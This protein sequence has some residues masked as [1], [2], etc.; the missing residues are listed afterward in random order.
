M[1]QIISFE[2]IDGAGKTYWAQ[3]I[4]DF[5]GEQAIYITRKNMAASNNAYINEMG[6]HF[7]KILWK[8]GYELPV[9]LIPD[10]AWLCLH[11]AW[12]F[13]FQENVL[14]QLLRKYKYVIL[15]GWFYKILARFWIKSEYT[16]QVLLERF[17]D[18][19]NADRI[20]FLDINPQKCFERKESFSKCELGLLDGE[21]RNNAASF[22]S[23]QNKVRKSYYEVFASLDLKIKVFDEF[24]DLKRLIKEFE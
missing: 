3:S 16:N 11:L 12:Y 24:V 8:S 21:E 2:G 1:G 23:Y 9:E 15:D 6:R 18:L 20:F 13:I 17:E 5:L 7:E 14:K 4:A 10:E 22:I 19:I